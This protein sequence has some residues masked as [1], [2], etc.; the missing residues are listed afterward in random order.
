VSDLAALAQ[1]LGSADPEERRRAVAELDGRDLDS[2]SELVLR[3]LGDAD[4]RVR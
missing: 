4:W 3:A 1:A 2:C